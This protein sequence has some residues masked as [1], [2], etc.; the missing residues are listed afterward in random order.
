MILVHVLYAVLQFGASLRLV[1]GV[2]EEVDV[3]VQRELVHRIDLAQVGE[4]EEQDG[5]PSGTRTVRLPH[6]DTVVV[7]VGPAP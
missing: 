7:H 1:D 5:G 2:G 3:C 4:H 6:R